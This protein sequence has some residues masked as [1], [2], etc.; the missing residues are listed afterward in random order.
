MSSLMTA[1][2]PAPT[3][4]RSVFQK[5]VGHQERTKGAMRELHLHRKE[6]LIRPDVV[7]VGVSRLILQ[8]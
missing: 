3:F 4:S 1:V 5:P 8:G 2:P 6:S 7:Y